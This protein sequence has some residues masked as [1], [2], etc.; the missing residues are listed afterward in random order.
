[1]RRRPLHAAV[2]K[3]AQRR[4]DDVAITGRDRWIEAASLQ[5]GVIDEPCRRGGN[6]PASC[7]LAPAKRSIGR[8]GVNAPTYSMECGK[9]GRRWPSNSAARNNCYT[10]RSARTSR[11]NI[12]PPD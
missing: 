6:A 5:R 11:G 7:R 9:P 3:A 4:D 2:G 10:T 8:G 12:K 1:M